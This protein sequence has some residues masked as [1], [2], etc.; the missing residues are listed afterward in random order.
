MTGRSRAMTTAVLALVALT[1]EARVGDWPQFHGPRRDNRSDETGLMRSWPEGGPRLLWTAE[2]LG[3]GYTSVAV[4]G[5]MIYTAGK[6][7]RSTHVFAFDMSGKPRWRAANGEAWQAAPRMRWAVRYDGSRGTP[8]VSD[9]VVY[10]LGELGRLAAFEAKTGR[11]A[12]S[13]NVLERFE[14]KRP[15]YGLCESVLI[16]GEKLI[17]SPGGA[18]GYMVALDRKTGKTLWANTDI[19]DGVGY[20]SAVVA[21][22]G[23]IRQIVTMSAEALFGVGAETGKLLW[24]VPH[25]N[26]RNNSCTDPI[27]S[28]GHVYAST[29][30]GG[31]SVLVKL[32][33][34]GGGIR[35]EKVWTSELL[36]NHHGGVVLAAGH[37]YGSGHESR[38]WFCLDFLTGEQKHRADGK[39]SLTWADGMLYCLEENGAMSL[40]EATPEGRRVVSSFQVPSGGRGKHW[41]H[42]VVCGGRLYVRHADRLFAYDV[43]AK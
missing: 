34:A 23:G 31:G 26:K 29:G 37:L 9:G 7:E 43:K 8:T 12:W 14:A 25:S 35:A 5:G 30:Y 20:C 3:K 13:A 17:C 40:V 24:R 11:E 27:C 21:E 41:S 18:R 28:D 22:L 33:A 10:H 4:A 32:T 15:S 1:S 38:G 36:D 19:S 6:I 16:D 39:G 2:G 42:P